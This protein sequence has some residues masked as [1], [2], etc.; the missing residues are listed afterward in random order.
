MKVV[1]IEDEIPAQERLQRLLDEIDSS[2]KVVAKIESVREGVK[3]F[4]NNEAPDL[5]FMDIQ[6]ADG[7]SFSIFQ[8]IELNIPTIFCTAYDE[9]AIQAFKHNSI[10]YL[11]KP[12]DPAELK[13]ALK[14]YARMYKTEKQSVDLELLASLV[15]KETSTYK[16]RFMV[17]LGDKIQSISVREIA[18]FYSEQKATLIVTSEGKKHFV[19]Y[20]MDQ[21]QELL[22]P[23]MF[24]RLNRKYLTSF[25]AIE[26]V[27][28][29]SNSRLKVKLLN[30]ADEQI[31]V[32]R[33]KVGRLKEWLDQ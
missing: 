2:I 32:S 12:I 16:S 9:Y 5:L 31:I 18:F 13:A 19:D 3:Y 29:Y 21:V 17:K 1:I 25:V 26:G 7:L 8:S 28:V 22:N 20:T 4:A 33:E 11:L 10:D 15:K 14:K 27:F 6:L 24:F 23:Q 30:C